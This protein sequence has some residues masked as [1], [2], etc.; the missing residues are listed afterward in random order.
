MTNKF[1]QISLKPGFM[2]HNGGL[3]FR[4]VSENE[5]E[6]KTIINENHLNKAGITHGGFICSI[7][8]AGS[9]TA[10]H[11]SAK[12]FPCVTI[13]LDV[14]FIGPTKKGDEILGSV[15]ILKKTK[16]MIFLTCQLICK[17][18]IIANASGVWKMLKTSQA[19]FGPGG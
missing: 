15:K 10:A 16:S 19:N 4:T 17:K 13:S 9:G 5:Y 2:K 7:I 3:L 6:F 8:D 11:K 14:K 18:K 1:E 12:S